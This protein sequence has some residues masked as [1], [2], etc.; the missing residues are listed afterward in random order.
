ML[1][2]KPDAVIAKQTNGCSQSKWLLFHSLISTFQGLTGQPGAK[3][4]CQGWAVITSALF[5]L[6]ELLAAGSTHYVVGLCLLSCSQTRHVPFQVFLLGHISHPRDICLAS[7]GC[8]TPFCSVNKSAL[9][10]PRQS[11]PASFSRQCCY[12]GILLSQPPTCC[13]FSKKQSR[14]Q[15][16]SQCLYGTFPSHLVYTS[17]C[18]VCSSRLK[19]AYLFSLSGIHILYLFVEI[20]SS[21]PSN[22]S[23][24]VST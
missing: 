21:Y 11:E 23:S 7:L 8:Q 18:Q 14:L 9:Q 3:R 6:Q 17:V 16:V 4:A 24:N 13:S 22:A 15:T 5:F 1:T 2:F 12:A 10:N 20:Q 19:H